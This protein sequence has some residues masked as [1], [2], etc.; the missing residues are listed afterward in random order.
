MNDEYKLKH[1]KILK[2]K[3]AKGEFTPCVTNSWARSRCYVGDTPFRSNWEAYFYIWMSK[4]NYCLEYEKIRIKYFDSIQKKYRN[5]IT[6][7]VDYE[8]RIIY[9]IKPEG[10]KDTQN[11]IDKETAAKEWCL[12]NNFEFIYISD[13]WFMINYE[14]SLC[15]NDTMLRLLRQFKGE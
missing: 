4:N 7:F 8:N 15:I 14:E 6:D 11:V 1:S 13:S 9:E 10:C 12:I 2:E 5:Y 3:I